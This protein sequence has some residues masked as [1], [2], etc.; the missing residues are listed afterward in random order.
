MVK[1]EGA[2]HA[3]DR[4]DLAPF[5]RDDLPPLRDDFLP[6]DELR[7]L[8]PP[9]LLDLPPLLPLRDVERPVLVP[10]VLFFFFLPSFDF[11]FAFFA[12]FLSSTP[13]FL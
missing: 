6:R 13:F 11:F 7:A 3:L 8:L 12:L 4:E 2:S 1:R 9:L 5:E 10:P